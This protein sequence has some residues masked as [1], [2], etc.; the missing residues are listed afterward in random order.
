[1][2]YE[3]AA[4]NLKEESKPPFLI[5]KTK[6]GKE[7]RKSN[8][9]F[10]VT[11][12]AKQG[13]EKEAAEFVA[14]AVTLAK[15]E[16]NTLRWYAFQIDE[17]TLGVFDTFENEDGRQEHLHGKIAAALFSDKAKELFEGEPSIQKTKILSNK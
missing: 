8:I 10:L 2:E 5:V 14:S 7:K 17:S 9:G 3:K 13:K 15:Q 6:I 11:L 12:K 16:V 4:S 1:M